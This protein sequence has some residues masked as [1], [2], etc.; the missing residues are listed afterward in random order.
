MSGKGSNRRRE[1][2]A[3]V[4]ANWGAIF[5]PARTPVPEPED[6]PSLEDEVYS[7]TADQG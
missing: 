5:G 1:N 4:D 3:L 2:T 7:A 6:K